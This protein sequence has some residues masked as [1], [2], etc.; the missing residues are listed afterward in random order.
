LSPGQRE[1]SL[2]ADAGN[3]GGVALGRCDAL[4]ASG[5]EQ[6]GREGFIDPRTTPLPPPFVGF[7]LLAPP[8]LKVEDLC[9]SR[10]ILFFWM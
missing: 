10:R 7:F 6:I 2:E 8:V 3:P 9:A 4:E 1:A 5:R